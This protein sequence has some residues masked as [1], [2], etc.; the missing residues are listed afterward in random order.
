MT[1]VIKGLIRKLTSI[2]KQFKEEQKYFI[3]KK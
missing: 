3:L 2:K 1:K